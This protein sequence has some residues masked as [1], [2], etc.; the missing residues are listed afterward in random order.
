MEPTIAA[1]ATCANS[2]YLAIHG[3]LKILN[4]CGISLCIDKIDLDQDEN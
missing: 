3:T 4:R 2:I 1:I